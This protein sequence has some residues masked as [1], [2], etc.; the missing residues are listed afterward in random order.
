MWAVTI[1][2]TAKMLADAPPLRWRNDIAAF[3]CV[4]GYAQRDRAA[5]V[6]IVDACGLVSDLHDYLPS[7]APNAATYL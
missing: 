7:H 4:P 3:L 5:I 1:F 6:E 2:D